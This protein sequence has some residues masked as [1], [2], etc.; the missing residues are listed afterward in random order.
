M[1]SRWPALLA[2]FLLPACA[3][4][5][6]SPCGPSTCEGCCTVDGQCAAGDD[7]AACG[8]GGSTCVACWDVESCVERSCRG[9]AL[10]DTPTGTLWFM[11]SLSGTGRFEIA[12]AVPKTGASARVELSGPSVAGSATPS[13]AA[14]SPDGQRLAVVATVDDPA[15]A[16]LLVANP[17]G[18][19]ARVLVRG[20]ATPVAEVLEVDEAGVVWL[21][22]ARA[23]Y[24]TPL[25]GGVSVR[26]S[27]EPWAPVPGSRPR[28]SRSRDHRYV[29]IVAELDDGPGASR[30]WVT[31]LQATPPAP[32]EVLTAGQVGVGSHLG[33]RTAARF[34]ADDRAMVLAAFGDSATLPWTRPEGGTGL[35]LISVDPA[36]GLPRIVPGT[37]T[38]YSVVIAWGL[39]ADGHSAAFSTNNWRGG[40]DVFVVQLAELADAHQVSA[41]HP[42]GWPSRSDELVFSPDGQF[43]AF[44]ANWRTYSL[45]HPS[46]Q[47]DLYV[48]RPE[49]MN[50]VLRWQGAP[51]VQGPLAFSPDGKDVVFLSD[52]LTPGQLRPYAMEAGGTRSVPRAFDVLAPGGAITSVHWT[53]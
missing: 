38:G 20:D 13:S 2:L 22:D 31:D 18:T 11:G 9:P 50:E 35:R 19:E 53:P 37:P 36:G 52:H 33:A 3:A 40:F 29:S 27:P 21:D 25:D 7:Q 26:A 12:R 16:Q 5:A 14:V 49:G 48:A 8:S 45:G 41:T 6:T 42:T 46:E 47:F 4:T 28:V 24:V 51:S 43:V 44:T 34:A 23:V 17:D 1:T 39:S 30:V 15:R 10:D 32:R